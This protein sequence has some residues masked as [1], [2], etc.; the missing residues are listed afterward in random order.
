MNAED[1]VKGKVDKMIGFFKIS[2]ATK[3]SWS[4][5]PAWR[6][7]RPLSTCA[8]TRTSSAP[9][10]GPGWTGVLSAESS[11]RAQRGDTGLLRRCT[12]TWRN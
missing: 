10:A 11:W 4:V 1:E 3:E 5:R 2:I 9:P 6:L 8:R 7:P 12:K